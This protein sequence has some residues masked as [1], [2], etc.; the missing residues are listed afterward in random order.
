MKK[1]SLVYMVIV[2]VAA[3]IGCG[4]NSNSNSK[5]NMAG[6]WTVQTVS[7]TGLEST[8]LVNLVPGSTCASLD[9][10]GLVSPQETT[11][12]VADNFSLEGSVTGSG[13]FIYP[14]EGVLIG[15]VPG[16]SGSINFVFAEAASEFD[17]AVFQGTGTTTGGN[18]MQGTWACNTSYSLICAGIS[19]SF[20]GVKE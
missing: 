19:G 13:E 4:G 7:S 10:I 20:S 16:A 17:Y 1:N 5:M 8:L 12:F 14:P 11:C 6:S 18:L 15:I 2:L 3:L 9:P